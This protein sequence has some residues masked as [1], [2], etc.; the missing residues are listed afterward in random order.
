MKMYRGRR[1]TVSL[2]L[3][4]HDMEVSSQLHALGA[5]PQERTVVC[6]EWE[7]GWAPEPIRTAM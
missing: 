4:M 2:I 5:L 6:V 3:N 1:G 7:A